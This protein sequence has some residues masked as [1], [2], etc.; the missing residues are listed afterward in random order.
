ME[1]TTME[2][3]NDIT[4]KMLK[5]LMFAVLPLVIFLIIY[6][7]NQSSIVFDGNESIL[8]GLPNVVSSHNVMLSYSMGL[9]VKTAPLIAF[10]FFLFTHKNM[11][12][13]KEVA[14]ISLILSLLAYYFFYALIFYFAILSSHDIAGAG[15]ILR[16]FSE[17]N[18]LITIFYIAL[19]SSVYV[20]TVMLLWF[21]VGVFREL[22]E[23]G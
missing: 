22:K 12:V 2:V 1:S 4:K 20:L 18:I 13:K 15:R 23:R 11:M 8:Q 6:I 3:Q 21:S 5:V 14:A 19:Y 10:L 9:Y 7:M 16:L 17:N